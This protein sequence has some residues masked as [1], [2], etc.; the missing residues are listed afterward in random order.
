MLAALQPPSPNVGVLC[1][2]TTTTT[3][4]CGLQVTLG[5]F[6]KGLSLTSPRSR[7]FCQKRI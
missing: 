5:K 3:T 4:A 6:G 7:V 1:P 2:T